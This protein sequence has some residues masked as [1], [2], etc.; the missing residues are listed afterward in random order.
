MHGSLSCMRTRAGSCSV[1]ARDAMRHK[2]A[3]RRK[4]AK[5]PLWVKRGSFA[6]DEQTGFR[7]YRK[8]L[9]PDDNGV[10]T[11]NKYGQADVRELDRD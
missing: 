4:R 3:G 1:L 11:D 10:L 6:R 9:F 8:L 7:T 5:L 2:T